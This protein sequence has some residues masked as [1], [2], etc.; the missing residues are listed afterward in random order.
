MSKHRLKRISKKLKIGADIFKTYILF[1]LPN[2]KAYSMDRDLV[3]KLGLNPNSFENSDLQ[4]L[5]VPEHL[6]K[7]EDLDKKNIVVIELTE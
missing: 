1:Y 6:V 2:K 7:K 5:N 4:E 3:E